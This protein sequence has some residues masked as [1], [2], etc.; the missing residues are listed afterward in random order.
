MDIA[1]GL[2]NTHSDLSRSLP[3]AGLYITPNRR[4]RA[5]SQ[6]K[7]LETEIAGRPVSSRDQEQRA[8]NSPSPV[9][10]N[11]ENKRSDHVG[12]TINDV[13]KLESLE[14]TV[15][16]RIAERIA[17]FTGSMFFVWLHVAWFAL[18]IIFNIPWWGFQP[19]DPV[20][21]TFL[22][23]IV[24]LEAI[25]LSAFILISE[26]RQGRLADRRSRVN[27]QI[28]M[29]AEREITKLMELVVDIHARM[30]IQRA[31]DPELNSMTKATNIEH[32]TEAA[33]TV[34]ERNSGNLAANKTS[35]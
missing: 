4:R 2:G 16:E 7:V 15:S 3:V 22:T 28:D 29:I 11:V 9:A 20:P 18:W 35:K 17:A 10:A 12:E 13:L 34:E 32:L 25:F 1:L 6:I 5:V 31:V 33:Q 21:F 27:L 26:N 30:G 14:R 23:M 19:L 24:S 8:G